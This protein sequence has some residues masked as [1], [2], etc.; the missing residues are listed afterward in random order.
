MRAVASSYAD[1]AGLS[2]YTH[3]DASLSIAALQRIRASVA[4][5]I[6]R[7]VAR[8]RLDRIVAAVF[9][10]A[11]VPKEPRA[12]EDLERLEKEIRETLRASFDRALALEKRAD[13]DEERDARRARVALHRPRPHG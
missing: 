3:G 7:V 2:I 8:D 1:D 13:G 6:A 4:G 5:A 9:P 12:E 11:G 10:P